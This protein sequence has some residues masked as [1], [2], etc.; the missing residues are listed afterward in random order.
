MKCLV[1]LKATDYQRSTRTYNLKLGKVVF[2]GN[3]G[4]NS[5]KVSSTHTYCGAHQ[6]STVFRAPTPHA[7]NAPR[8][9]TAEG[10]TAKLSKNVTS[11]MCRLYCP[12]PGHLNPRLPA[13]SRC[14][15]P[16]FLIY[17]AG[18]P[19]RQDRSKF[20]V[21]GLPGNREKRAENDIADWPPSVSP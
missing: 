14:Q 19:V 7:V 21:Y 8:L 5:R 16:D 18:R 9:A 1:A 2:C 20:R 15:T 12:V 6:K 17:P 11:G 10:L 13:I 3:G 4:E